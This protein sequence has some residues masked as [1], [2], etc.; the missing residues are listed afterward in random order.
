M[1][2]LQSRQNVVRRASVAYHT[3]GYHGRPLFGTVFEVVSAVV[4]PR[5]SPRWKVVL[6]KGES[7]KVECFTHNA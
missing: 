1:N 6:A 7:P 4:S 5:K 2:H 3:V